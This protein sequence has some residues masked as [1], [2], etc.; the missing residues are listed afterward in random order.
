MEASWKPGQI[1]F[2]TNS[3]M[4]TTRCA[5]PQR[6]LAQGQP[7]SFTPPVSHDIESPAS[8]R[9]LLRRIVFKGTRHLPERGDFHG[10]EHRD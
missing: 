2:F 3:L 8:W 10:G 9:N 4:E 1:L 5:A 6:L 7:Q